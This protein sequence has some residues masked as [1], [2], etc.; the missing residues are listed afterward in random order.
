MVGSFRYSDILMKMFYID[1]ILCV[2]S[3]QKTGGAIIMDADATATL[4]KM[5]VVAT[6]DTGKFTWFQVGG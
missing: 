5:G 2:N 6:D 3:W 4:H 1:L